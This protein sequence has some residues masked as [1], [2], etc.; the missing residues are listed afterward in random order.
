[1][2]PAV[3]VGVNVTDVPEQIAPLGL[4]AIVTLGVTAAFTVSTTAADVAV[5]VLAQAALEVSTAVTL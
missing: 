2:P 5:V 4:A 1:M 3:G